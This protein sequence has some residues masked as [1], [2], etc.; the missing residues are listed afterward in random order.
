MANPTTNYGFV[1]PTPTDLVTDLPAD[2]DVALQGVDTQ[3]KALNPSTTLGD[4]DF[5]SAVANVNTR[6]AI[7]TAGQ[8]LTVAGGVPTWA[9]AAAAPAGVNFNKVIN[10]NFAINQRGYVSAATLAS[11]VYGLDRWKSNIA[12]TTLT[13]TA[14][15]NGNQLTI[16]ST[17]EIQQVVER[18]VI[19][20]G[21]NTLSWEGTATARMYNSGAVAPSYA[22][23]PITVNLDGLQNVVVEFTAAGGT[24]TVSNVKL[25][26]GTTASAFVLAGLTAAGEFVSCQRYFQSY[27][28]NG[29]REAMAM[30]SAFTATRAY[31]VQQFQ[32]QMRATPTLALSAASHFSIQE[33]TQNWPGTSNAVEDIKKN[34]YWLDFTAS[35][36]GMTAGRA[37]QFFGN[38]TSARLTLDAEL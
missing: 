7:G 32:V 36:A 9:A 21:N 5:S 2:F 3:I 28:G 13:F 22:A 4:T 31:V 14:A 19:P 17:G 16:N 1:L 27:G 12:G 37:I 34:S 26:A 11:G 8:I 38:S 15:V 35:T 20:A 25:E 24:R 33:A 18:Q 6:L 23:S 29:T 10:G 30:A